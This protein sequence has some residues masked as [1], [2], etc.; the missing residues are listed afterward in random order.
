[1]AWLTGVHSA[2][3]PDLSS[4]PELPLG[5]AFCGGGFAVYLAVLVL[6]VYS[7]AVVG[8]VL[9]IRRRILWRV[10]FGTFRI[11]FDDIRAV[12]RSG[13]GRVPM[14]ILS[15]GWLFAPDGLVLT[16]RKPRHLFWRRVF[17]APPN[18]DA[19]IALLSE[20]AGVTH[21]I[22]SPVLRTPLDRVPV[23]VG[24]ILAV[25]S[26]VCFAAFTRLV[27]PVPGL[28]RLPVATQVAPTLLI[29]MLMLLDAVRSLSLE[30]HYRF[31]V[32]IVLIIVFCP[33]AWPY[34]LVEWRV[35][36]LRA[37]AARWE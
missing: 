29:W 33:L 3:P 6:P 37:A 30:K 32:W 14:A 36:R 15:Y 1:M 18:P 27:P 13:F 23:W 10:P 22:P 24:G 12:E 35:R 34:Y 21:T 5:L 7:Y 17:I 2:M 28:S 8:R 31:L 20:A 19:L 11:P 9:V 26:V 16:L 25:L 4:T